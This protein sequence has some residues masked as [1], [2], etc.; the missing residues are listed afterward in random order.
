MR[1]ELVSGA[2]FAVIALAQLMRT[3]MAVPVR[4]GAVSVPVWVSLVA[5]LVT[6]SLAVWAFS[7][8]RR[9]A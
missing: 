8:A 7:T 2:L 5:F 6:A 3:V 4:V 9:T 1:Y